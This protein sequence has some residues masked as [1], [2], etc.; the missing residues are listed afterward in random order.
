[1]AGILVIELGWSRPWKVERAFKMS[2]LCPGSGGRPLEDSCSGSEP[3][4]C[5]GAAVAGALAV[6]DTGA[7]DVPRGPP[8][9]AAD[10][11]SAAVR[12]GAVDSFHADAAGPGDAANSSECSNPVDPHGSDAFASDGPGPAEAAPGPPERWRPAEWPKATDAVARAERLTLAAAVCVRVRV[13]IADGLTVGP[14][15]KV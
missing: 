13:R 14:G 1:M 6:A 7:C 15:K 8:L 3:I 11:A 9:A 2:F 4:G 12:A 10:G 5:P